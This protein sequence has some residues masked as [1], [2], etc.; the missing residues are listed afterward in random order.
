M[1]C[2]VVVSVVWGEILNMQQKM[3][4]M[5]KGWGSG[6][7]RVDHEDVTSMTQEFVSLVKILFFIIVEPVNYC[8]ACLG[9]HSN[10]C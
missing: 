3:Q 8:I 9:S 6:V 5:H 7:I 1:Q 2:H 4:N 10:H